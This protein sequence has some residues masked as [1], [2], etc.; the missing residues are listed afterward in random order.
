M[1][2]TEELKSQIDNYFDNISA[3]ELYCVLTNK[4]HLPDADDIYEEGE[5][6]SSDKW[7]FDIDIENYSDAP[8]D[9]L[10]TE[11]EAVTVVSKDASDK[12]REAA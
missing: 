4:Y 2:L 3:E 6:M 9:A 5:Y 12:Y 1:K 10:V 8:K 7:N 11:Y